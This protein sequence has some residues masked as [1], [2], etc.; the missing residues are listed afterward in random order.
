MWGHFAQELFF[1]KRPTNTVAGCRLAA[2]QNGA[3]QASAAFDAF[4]LNAVHNMS[5]SGHQICKPSVAE[6]KL[7]GSTHAPGSHS[8]PVKRVRARRKKLSQ[9]L[10]TVSTFWRRPI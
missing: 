6:G 2:L 9:L 4:Q 10:G 1:Y 3:H 8:I 5:G 7:C